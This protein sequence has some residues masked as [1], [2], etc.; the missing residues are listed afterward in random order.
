MIDSR[1][2]AKITSAR[3]RRP[4]RRRCR[5]GR[6]GAGISSAAAIASRWAAAVAGVAEEGEQSAHGRHPST[7]YASADAAAGPIPAG[8]PTRVSQRADT[9]ERRRPP[10]A[11]PAY[12]AAR[13]RSR[14]GERPGRTDEPATRRRTT[15]TSPRRSW[16]SCGTGWR[17]HRPAGR[18]RGPRRP[19]TPGAGPRSSAAFPGETLVIPTGR[20]KVRANDT[21]Y[22]FRPGSD[23]VYLTGEH[24]PDAVLVLRPNGRARRD[25]VHAGPRSPRDTDEFFRKPR[26]ASCGSAAGT[27]WPRSRPSWASPTARPDRAGRGAGR[28]GAGPH[29]GAA[30]LRRTRSTRPCARTTDRARPAGPRP[31]AGDRALRA[32]AGQGRVGDR[33]AAGRDRRHR[34]RLRGRGP[35]AAGRPGGLRAAARGRLRAARP[36]RRQRRRLRLDRRRRRARH[37]PALG[38]QHTAPPRRASCC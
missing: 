1:L 26:T 16:R 13:T 32:A 29:P 11:D 30:R 3:R 5:P 10:P 8:T 12:A 19:T 35:G 2:C 36:A 6:G 34:A 23:F 27:P 4:P 15:R 37:D 14:R 38:P 18:P 33:P 9:V 7:R 17:R 24:D 31:G 20:E 28:P 21:D 22:P 25:P